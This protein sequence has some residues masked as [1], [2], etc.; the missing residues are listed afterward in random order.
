MAFFRSVLFSAGHVGH[1]LGG[2]GARVLER[3]GGPSPSS[4]LLDRG[5]P[6]LPKR[7]LPSFH[8]HLFEEDVAR[9]VGALR[10]WE[11]SGKARVCW[12]LYSARDL[13]SYRFYRLGKRLPRSMQ[14]HA[15]FGASS[16]AL[17]T[18]AAGPMLLL[19]VRLLE[20]ERPGNSAAL[21][22]FGPRGRKLLR[23]GFLIATLQ[24]TARL[25]RSSVD[26]T[27]F[28]FWA[29]WGIKRAGL[30]GGCTS[31]IEWSICSPM[32]KRRTSKTV[33]WKG[34]RGRPA[35]SLFASRKETRTVRV[36]SVLSVLV[37]WLA[38]SALLCSASSPGRPGASQKVF[39]SSLVSLP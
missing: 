23:K 25:R 14:H 38:G 32:Q 6:K 39:P 18:P 30:H 13:Q 1:A 2:L 7:P 27:C 28:R 24:G 21:Q 22:I 8:P 17:C 12:D 4:G 29:Q 20:S 9:R 31:N 3:I 16:K 33:K 34:Q 36:L 15:E 26:R 10:A 19:P 5:E 37:L 35:P 11:L